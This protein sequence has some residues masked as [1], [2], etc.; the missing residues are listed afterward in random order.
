MRLRVLAPVVLALALALAACTTGQAVP[1]TTQ[2]TTSTTQPTPAVDLS[3]TPPG[4]VPV[5]YGDAQISV[6]A[7]WYVLYSQPCDSGH[8]P[9]EVFVD[10]PRGSFSCPVETAPLPTTTVTL[11]PATARGYQPPSLYGHRRVINGISVFPYGAA[12]Y[13]VPSLGVEISV[14]GVLGQRVLHTLTRSP[15]AVALAPGPGPSV[16]SSWRSVSFA[17][18]RFSVPATWPVQHT[19]NW[20]V[21]GAPQLVLGFPEGVIL[22]TDR[23]FLAL[24][25][26]EPAPFALPPSDGVRVDSGR[27]GPTGSF[28]PGGACLRVGGLTACPSGSPAY[29]ILLLR[30]TV[31]GRTK[32]VMLSIG[33]AGNG[34]VARTIL[35][36]L[37]AA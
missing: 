9:G 3:A 5:V 22:D 13:I 33:L 29:S 19:A 10:P 8:P 34:M 32:P 2:P 15:R 1:P 16:P 7:D 20:D 12:S 26:A 11:L 25:C 6:P 37:R 35:Y 17:G 21:C 14:G 27:Q 36:S 28:S 30:V 23:Y 4:W 31:P 24:P 18:L